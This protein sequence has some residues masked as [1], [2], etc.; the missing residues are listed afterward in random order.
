M[1]SK[2]HLAVAG[3]VALISSA[4]V[5]AHVRLIHPS[6]GSPL[7]WSAP[8]NIGIVINDVGSDNLS[9]GSDETALRSA[10]NEWNSISGT[11]LNLVENTSD[12]AQARTDWA[13]NSI[14]LLYFDENNSSGYFPGGSSTV[15]ITPVWFFG[16]GRID[17]ADVLFNGSGFNFTTSQEVGRY[18]IEDVAVHEI[19]HLVGLDHTGWA[20]GSMY[21]YVD[22]SVILHRSLSQDEHQAMRAIYSGGSHATINGN[23]KRLSDSTAV[24][25]ANVIVRDTNGRTIAADLTNN[26][27]A[28]A[29]QGLDGG[30]Y[31]LYVTPLDFPVSSGNL[32]SG[33]TIQTDFEST[34]HGNVVVANGSTQSVG[35]VFVDAN[36]SLSLGRNSDRYPLRTPE[37][38]T[39]NLTI[40]GSGLNAGSI[41]SCSDPSIAIAPINW[42]GS[43]VTCSVNVPSGA[44]SGHVDVMVTNVGGDRSILPAGLEITPPDP[45]VTLAS[46]N[47][48]DIGGGTSVMITGTEFN[49][50]ARVVFG[51]E[52]YEDG[53]P[54]GCV[55]VNSTTITLVTRASV[56]GISDVVVIDG[57]GVEGRQ[58]DGFQFLAVPVVDTVFPAVGSATGSTEIRITGANFDLNSVVRINGVNQAG[59]FP[60]SD[61]TLAVVTSAGALGG[62]FLLEVENPGGAL[63]TASYSYVA[64]P[65]PDVTTVTP[66]QGKASGG[67]TILIHGSNFNANTTVIFGADPDTGVGGTPAAAINLLNSSTIEVTTPAHASGTASVI[68]QDTGTGQAAVITSGFQFQSS[69]GGGGGGGGCHT[70]PVQGPPDWGDVM[71]SLLW[72][73]AVLVGASWMG[74]PRRR[75]SLGS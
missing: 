53:A 70:L 17:D 67:E 58:A 27:G 7:F 30:T 34:I 38:E 1:I 13:S 14:H 5:W 18:D 56:P 66:P 40:R 61:D 29:I 75:V 4:A 42:F 73:A 25:G 6:N 9:D 62:P 12:A 69:G 33:W 68:A 16:N 60:V 15:A 22:P 55:V 51:G 2:K 19:G 46:P 23:I 48:G 35:D 21:P 28:F 20:G 10:I 3:G 45:T 24:R 65:D 54:G 8:G 49:P 26:S 32:G 50:G 39:T 63:A 74:R 31:E 71:R 11:N 41:L 37:G 57:S 44:A 72:F 52:I 47:Q 36:V 59:T 43:Q 64:N